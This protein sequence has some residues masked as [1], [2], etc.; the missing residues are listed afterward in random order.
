MSSGTDINQRKKDH[1]DL[2]LKSQ[3][4]KADDRFYYEPAIHG[5][6]KPSLKLPF[7][8]PSA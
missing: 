7:Q 5:H 2:A 4:L 3:V 6:P 8:L 1:I